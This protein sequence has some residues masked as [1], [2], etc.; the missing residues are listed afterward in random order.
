MNS[1]F[2][3][4]PLSVHLRVGQRSAW[5][6]FSWLGRW[7]PIGTV[8]IFLLPVILASC[9]TGSSL[10]LNIDGYVDNP[11]LAIAYQCDDR[12]VIEIEKGRGLLLV[13]RKGNKEIYSLAPNES[14]LFVKQG[15]SV[16]LKGAELE[17]SEETDKQRC[18]L[19]SPDK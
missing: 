17:L 6:N 5:R 12:S 3:T 18:I 2:L 14:K 4:N 15:S 10:E 1:P 9:S 13:T 16:L 8:F 11:P 19:V 7:S